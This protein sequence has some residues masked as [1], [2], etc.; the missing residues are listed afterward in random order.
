MGF[1]FLGTSAPPHL[2]ARL[3]AYG[4]YLSSHSQGSAMPV[5]GAPLSLRNRRRNRCLCDA[6]IIRL[7][8]CAIQSRTYKINGYPEDYL[9]YLIAIA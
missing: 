3:S 5:A 1:R 7:L 4:C 2:P 9:N 8:P 6:R